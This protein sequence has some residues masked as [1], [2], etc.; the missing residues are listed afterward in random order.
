MQQCN[1]IHTENLEL[2]NRLKNIGNVNRKSIP[3]L[4]QLRKDFQKSQQYRKIASHYKNLPNNLVQVK[5]ENEGQEP[6]ETTENLKNIGLLNKN[7]DK[8]RDNLANLKVKTLELMHASKKMERPASVNES[9]MNNSNTYFPNST[10]EAYQPKLNKI[11]PD[12]NN[13]D[14]V[15]TQQPITKI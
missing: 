1:R 6:V 8:I 7:N 12:I 2:Y 11:F 15:T 5:R 13:S 14:L 9:D 10:I 4:D 3:S